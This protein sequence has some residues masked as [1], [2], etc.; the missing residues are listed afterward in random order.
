MFRISWVLREELAV[1]PAPRKHQHAS[2]LMEQGIVGI[3]ALCGEDEAPPLLLADNFHCGRF[4]LP[5]HRSGRA[6]DREE[7]EG[8]L[9]HLARLH[10]LG[11]VYV[12]CKAGVERSPL[13]CLAWLMKKHHL[14]KLDALDYLMQVHPRTGVLPQQLHVLSQLL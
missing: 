12:H 1:G 6:P 5:D 7:L 9:Q 11:P 14:H 10:S 4:V 3:L 2:M 13:V 8:A